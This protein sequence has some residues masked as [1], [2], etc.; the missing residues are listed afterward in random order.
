MCS[1]AS[2]CRNPFTILV[3]GAGVEFD[4]DYRLS[5]PQCALTPSN[6]KKMKKR[7]YWVPH[8]SGLKVQGLTLPR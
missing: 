2:G 8:L 1:E 7:P 6:F 3:K 5:F 4:F